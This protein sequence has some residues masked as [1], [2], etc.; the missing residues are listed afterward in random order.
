MTVLCYHSH[1]TNLHMLEE[2]AEKQ[3][4]TSAPHVLP[5]EYISR[6]LMME[7][8]QVRKF[9]VVKNNAHKCDRTDTRRVINLNLGRSC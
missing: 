4:A 8:A 5:S 3:M 9:L 1:A 7:Y 6:R 2:A